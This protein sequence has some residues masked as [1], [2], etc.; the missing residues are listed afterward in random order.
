MSL[1]LVFVRSNKSHNIY[2]YI[3]IYGCKNSLRS[4]RS[5]EETKKKKNSVLVTRVDARKE[6]KKKKGYAVHT[7]D[8]NEE[9]LLCFTFKKKKDLG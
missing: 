1:A 8:K 5:T 3:Y 9:Q 4:K 7:K 2:I 6:Q